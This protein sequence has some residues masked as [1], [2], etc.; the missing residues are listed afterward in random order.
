MN[1]TQ[2]TR[3]SS[4]RRGSNNSDEDGQAGSNKASPV[5]IL[6]KNRETNTLEQMDA[7]G[8]LKVYTKEEDYNDFGPKFGNSHEKRVML[9][10]PN[11]TSL[12]NNFMAF[13]DPI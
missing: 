3:H 9:Y 10:R 6:K 5:S 2:A 12:K 8:P 11:T 4:G 7:G 13:D 1:N